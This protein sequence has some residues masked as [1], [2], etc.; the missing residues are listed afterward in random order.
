MRTLTEHYFLG[1]M[2]MTYVEGM[3]LEKELKERVSHQGPSAN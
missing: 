1:D 2:N 3:V